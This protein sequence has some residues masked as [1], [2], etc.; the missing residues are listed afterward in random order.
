MSE[1]HAPKAFN[2]KATLVLFVVSLSALIA[3]YSSL[4]Y[5][6][7]GSNRIETNRITVS[8]ITIWVYYKEVAPAHKEGVS[9]RVLNATVFD[10]MYDEY[11][12]RYWPYPTG[13]LI[14]YINAAGP[15]WNYKV[16]TESPSIAC[17]KYILK[18]DSVITWTQV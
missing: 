11:T 3:V 2:K 14:E 9:S 1:K 6:L 5:F 13:Y 4:T 15:S 16:G 7:G 18:N 10:I 12:I 8:N 17:N